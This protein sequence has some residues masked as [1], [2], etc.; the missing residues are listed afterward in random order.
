VDPVL[1]AGRGGIFQVRADGK[2]L[3][4]KFE[5]HR[6]PQHEEILAQL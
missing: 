6:F 1:V 4:D 3:W 2:L 5:T